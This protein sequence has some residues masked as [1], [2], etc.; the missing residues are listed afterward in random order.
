LV[1][2]AFDQAKEQLKA[3][4]S[5]LARKSGEHL[6]LRTYVVLAI[7]LDRLVGQKLEDQDA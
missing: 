7:G 4:R 3:Y 1:K 2:N 5:A 6:K